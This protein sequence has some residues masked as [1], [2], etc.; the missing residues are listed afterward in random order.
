[1]TLLTRFALLISLAGCGAIY[2]SPE[3]NPIAGSGE[4]VRVV[5]MT[6]ES[7]MLANRSTYRPLALPAVFSQTAGGGSGLRGTGATPE[8]AIDSRPP[9][10]ALETR[11]PP[12]VNPGPYKIGIG[13]VVLLAT[14]QVGGTVAE[15][16]GLLAA[17]NSRQGYT[18]QDDGAI[19]IPNVGRV[20]IAGMTLEEA[21]A[22]LFQQLVAHQIDPSFSLEISEFNSKK[23]SVGG[24]VARPAVAPITL[25]PLYLDAALAA[26]GGVTVTDPDYASIRIYRDGT[27]YQIPLND[28]YSK[29]GMKRIQL[30]DGDSVFVDTSYNLDLAQ[31][32]FAE[33][34][35]L[36][37][38]KQAARKNALDELNAE[39]A[40]R[41]GQLQ[42][43]RQ[44]FQTRL[45]LDGIKRDYVYLTGEVGKQGRFALPFDHVATLA[46]AIY[47][48]DG[49]PTRTG[50]VREIYVL[51][52]SDDPREFASVTAWQLNAKNAGNL[53]LATRFELRPND[54][55]F[56]AEQPVTRWNRVIQ[57]ITPSL[58]STGINA[59]NN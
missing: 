16:T 18:V 6:G 51:R 2:N 24:A 29:S 33:Q 35:Q 55:V 23:V 21:E 50:N 27:I 7:V 45:S 14:P 19:A 58:I 10:G 13:D 4:K 41:R 59:S 22:E 17:Q 46:D 42:E 34:I 26:A 40:L 38:F 56:V 9:N 15:L 3:V 57:Q 1:M 43:E 5:P 25:T 53:L 30:I 12:P 49:V 47:S 52:G 39:V 48:N 54:V 44:N 31:A 20:Q 37:S 8:P 32:Y 28:L 36:A 11:L